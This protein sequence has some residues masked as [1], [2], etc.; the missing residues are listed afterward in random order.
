MKLTILM[1]LNLVSF[2]T[3]SSCVKEP[4]PKP[5][6]IIGHLEITLKYL[7]NK[8]EDSIP[9]IG[10]YGMIFEAEA[11]C[12][13][14]WEAIQGF[15]QLDGHTVHTK[16]YAEANENGLVRLYGMIEG[17][18][19]LVVTSKKKKRYSEKIIEISACDTLKLQKIFTNTSLFR[20]SLEPWD[21]VME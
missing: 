10:S 13:D 19:Y 5:E 12:P 6:S 2:I 21:Y 3:Y 4:D 17:E 14:Y 1:I 11:R 20:D 9:D 15:A 7:T 16:L 18:Y 8:S